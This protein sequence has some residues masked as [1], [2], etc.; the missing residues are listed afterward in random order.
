MLVVGCPGALTF[1]RHNY[2]RTL[3]LILL[4]S[5]NVLQYL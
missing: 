2:A 5:D 1:Q 3:L 4:T